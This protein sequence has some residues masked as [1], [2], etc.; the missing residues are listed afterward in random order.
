L[1]GRAGISGFILGQGDLAMNTT[2]G[3]DSVLAQMRATAAQVTPQG[4]AAPSSTSGA[5]FAG[6]L[7]DA[8]RDVSAQQSRG[9]ELKRRLD[10]DPNLALQDVVIELSKASLSF[11]MM[12]QVR[13]RLVSAYREVMN[14]QI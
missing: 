3:I 9:D 12:V 10:T 13:E 14:M 7:A 8:L 5:G 1:R 2:N 4:A 6:A 11:Q